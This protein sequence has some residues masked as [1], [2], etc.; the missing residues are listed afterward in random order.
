MICTITIVRYPKWMGWA[1]LLSMALF[2]LPLWFHKNIQFWKLMGS[3]RN[4]T[5]DMMPDWRQWAMLAVWSNEYKVLDDLETKNAKPQIPNFL[6]NWWR[7]FHCEKWTIV[8]EPIEGHGTWDGKNCF[9]FI[10]KKTDYDGPIAILTRATIRFSKLQQFWSN[11]DVVAGQMT[12]APGFITSFGIGEVP[13]IKQATFSIWES[14]EA[15]KIFAYQMKEHATVIQKTR[16]ENWY[17]E[18]MFVRFKIIST[19]GKINGMNPL[20]RKL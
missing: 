17:S 5:F 2:R 9:G 14:K 8:L 3:G 19:E 13:F 7:F 6:T 11:V 4:G 16:K 1:G 18:E 20:D 15:M 10:P 12:N